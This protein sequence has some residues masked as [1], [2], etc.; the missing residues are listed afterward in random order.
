MG[1]SCVKEAGNVTHDY[2][3]TETR[4]DHTNGNEET[5]E[6]NDIAINEPVVL[7]TDD[8][9]ENNVSIKNIINV[10]KY[11]QNI[12]NND[13]YADLISYKIMQTF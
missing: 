6:D 10:L 4:H 12:L 1:A 8:E 13:N 7:M 9:I 3:H 5:V 11:Y 2:D